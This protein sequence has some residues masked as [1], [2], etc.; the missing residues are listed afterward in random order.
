LQKAKMK[1]LLQFVFCF[2]PFDF[3]MH[4]YR[5]FAF[6]A[7]SV[8]LL[9]FCFASSEAAGRWT[10]QK[11]NTLAWLHAVYFVNEK[12]GWVVG[13][14]GVILAT[15]DGGATWTSLK[16]PTEDKL[17][18]VFFRNENEGWLICESNF[19]QL[20]EGEPLSYLL[21]TT[22]GGT[23]WQRVNLEGVNRE[24]RLSRFIIGPDGKGWLIGE[25]GT[26]YATRDGGKTWLSQTPPS[27]FL[28]LGGA[29][30]DAHQSWLV[31]AGST[32]V[33]TYDGGATWRKGSFKESQTTQKTGAASAPERVKFYSIS[34]V[35]AERGWIVGQGGKIYATTD[36]GHTWSTQASGVGTDLFD[37]KVF[38][39]GEGWS[40]GAGGTLLYTDN[41]GARWTKIE[42]ET[43]HQL[44]RLFFVNRNRGW[45]V[46]FGGTI[47]SYSTDNP[48]TRS[49]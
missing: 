40:T 42:T 19:Y 44:E 32:I 20:K 43:K 10:E 14:N 1:L 18:D 5:H 9:C 3:L 23:T 11:S 17:L 27:R 15:N 36:G 45:V 31:G 8:L 2:L 41:G 34:I 7:G 29:M 16:R 22:D 28:L 39:S 13:G 37:V 46:G 21:R 48:S 12:K 49:S 26:L 24:A 47:L 38:D 6:I 25:A 30:L 33:Y 4:C 35:D